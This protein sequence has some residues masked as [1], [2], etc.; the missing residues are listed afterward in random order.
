LSRAST[1]FAIHCRS[2]HRLLRQFSEPAATTGHPIIASFEPGED[3]FYDYEKRGM[4]K[5]VELLPPRSHPDQP[6]TGPAG[7]LPANGVDRFLWMGAGL[8]TPYF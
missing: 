1:A 7:R 2:S 4:I 3:C 8:G 5:D 6:P